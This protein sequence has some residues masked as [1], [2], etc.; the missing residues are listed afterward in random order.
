[1]EV[2]TGEILFKGVYP[3]EPTEN[4]YI[5]VDYFTSQRLDKDFRFFYYRYIV[6]WST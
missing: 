1:M 3:F 5:F 6:L 4:V 2:V